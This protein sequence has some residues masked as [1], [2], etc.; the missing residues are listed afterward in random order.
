MSLPQDSEIFRVAIAAAM[1][2]CRASR[3]CQ[4]IAPAAA[5]RDIFV[6]LTSQA[7]ADRCPSGSYPDCAVNAASTAAFTAVSC[8]CAR[9][10][11]ASI[12]PCAWVPSDAQSVAA[13]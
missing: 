13:R 6:R 11:W 2:P 4:P 3:R 1:T 9:C 8:A 12:S 7:I 10:S 5:P